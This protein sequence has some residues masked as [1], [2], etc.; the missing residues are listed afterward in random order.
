MKNAF[1]GMGERDSNDFS[2]GLDAVIQ[3]KTEKK[4]KWK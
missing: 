2:K 4:S 3:N 1:I